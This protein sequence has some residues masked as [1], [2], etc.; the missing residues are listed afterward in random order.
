MLFRDAHALHR[1]DRIL[2][3]AIAF[4][5]NANFLPPEIAVNGIPLRHF[6]VAIALG[7]AHA[8]A[9]TELANEGQH[10]PLDVRGRPLLRIV[11]K[12]LVFDLQPAQ[13]MVEEI[14]FLINS[15]ERVPFTD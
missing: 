4:F 12:D 5:P 10:L 8:V 2:R 9:I 1:Q 14:Q 7:K 3:A 15:H 13:L 11:E 6:V